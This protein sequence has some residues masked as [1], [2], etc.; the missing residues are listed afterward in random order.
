MG[1]RASSPSR[2]G[3]GYALPARASSEASTTEPRTRKMLV[4]A[5]PRVS[6]NTFRSHA[7]ITEASVNRQNRLQSPEARSASLQ[8][9]AAHRRQHTPRT[10]ATGRVAG[11][12]AR[13]HA[14]N[15]ED[16]LL[17]FTRNADSTSLRILGLIQQSDATPQDCPSE[18]LR[19]LQQCYPLLEVVPKDRFDQLAVTVYQKEGDIYYQQG[20]IENAKNAYSRAITLAEKRVARQDTDMY[21]VL[22]RYVL[23]MVG[24]ARIWYEH[25][26]DHQGFTFVNQKHPKVPAAEG[27]DAAADPSSSVSSLESSLI[28]D[29]GSVFSLNQAILKSMAPRPPRRQTGPLFQ[30]VKVQAPHV[31]QNSQC[32]REDEFVLHS[33]MTRELVASPCELLLLRCCE[34]VQIGHNAQSEL[35]IPPQIELAQI[36]EDLALYSR[37][38]LFVRRCVGI[39]CS[40][41]DY[42]HPWVVNLMQRADKLEELLEKQTRNDMATKIQATWKMHRAMQQLEAVLGHPV[43]RHHWI[44]RKYRTTPDLDFLGEYIDYMPEDGLLGDNADDG[45]YGSLGNDDGDKGLQTAEDN[46]TVPEQWSMVPQTDPAHEVDLHSAESHYPAGALVRYAPTEHTEGGDMF[47]AVVPN[48]TVVGTTQDTQTDTTVQH[49]EC[50]D[51][52]TV[53]TTTVTKTITEDV[54]YSSH[55][56]TDEESSADEEQSAASL[57]RD[58][59]P[60][61]PQ[62]R[63][64]TC[65]EHPPSSAAP[66]PPDDDVDE[67][68]EEREYSWTERASVVPQQQQQ[69]QPPPLPMQ[70]EGQTQFPPRGQTAS[71]QTRPPPLR[72]DKQTESAGLPR[73]GE[74]EA[75]PRPRSQRPASMARIARAS[76]TGTVPWPASDTPSIALHPDSRKSPLPERLPPKPERQ[77]LH[78]YSSREGESA[79]DDGSRHPG[80]SG[81]SPPSQGSNDADSV[82]C[83]EEE[84]RSEVFSGRDAQK[85][86]SASARAHVPSVRHNSRREQLC[87]LVEPNTL[88]QKESNGCPLFLPPLG[89]RGGSVRSS[90]SPSTAPQG[91]ESGQL[92]LCTPGDSGSRSPES[93]KGPMQSY[94]PRYRGDNREGSQSGMPMYLAAPANE[95]Q[96]ALPPVA[97]QP[98][99]IKTTRDYRI[100]KTRRVRTYVREPASSSAAGESASSS[101][102]SVTSGESRR[103]V[104][105]EEDSASGSS[106]AHVDSVEKE[107]GQ[108]DAATIDSKSGNTSAPR[109]QQPSKKTQAGNV[110]V[111]HRPKKPRMSTPPAKPLAKP[112]GKRSSSSSSNRAAVHLPTPPLDNA[113]VAPRASEKDPSDDDSGVVPNYSTSTTTVTRRVKSGRNG[114]TTRTTRRYSTSTNVQQTCNGDSGD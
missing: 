10:K 43:R 49:T 81:V 44:P 59:R 97:Q 52:L 42:D 18:K 15:E 26:R 28:S 48:A 23:A 37:A 76:E 82:P 89:Y 107:E 106:S 60:P 8:Q 5:A 109:R 68:V 79:V 7:A 36:Y 6:A 74:V 4:N 30:R 72:S 32:N 13:E 50:G 80:Q 47:T 34:V 73:H 103:S 100:I 101:S 94:G 66:H 96:P 105:W 102:G 108:V 35:L 56:G 104:R 31:M 58:M 20:D 85:S 38:L 77:R 86:S 40:V 45:V 83:E 29:G 46:A 92:V 84:K 88:Y 78:P 3:S 114:T 67:F 90:Q 54:V 1:N 2:A 27:G 53:R 65:T 112:T 17:A 113:E 25:Q 11:S 41:Y 93:K 22:K 75:P 69:Q 99:T 87:D 57:S 62:P 55:D 63:G 16:V 21:M 71:T 91:S 98:R 14:A 24:M 64:I 111:P 51:V 9:A 39:L 33:R 110:T 12:A 19:L 61:Q 95:Y 70:R